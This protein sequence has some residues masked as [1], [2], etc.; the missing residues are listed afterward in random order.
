MALQIDLS[1]SETTD[2]SRQNAAESRPYRDTITCHLRP[3]TLAGPWARQRESRA[4]GSTRPR[5]KNPVLFGSRYASSV[6]GPAMAAEG[7]AN[8]V[9]FS[10]SKLKLQARREAAGGDRG[11]EHGTD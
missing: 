4:N 9:V 10:Y 11:G 7:T 3:W 5:N 2:R 6:A 1:G 8:T